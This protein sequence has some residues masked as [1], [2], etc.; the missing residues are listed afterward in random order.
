[1]TTASP[2]IPGAYTNLVACADD[3][4]YYVVTV[5]DG[6][7]I[8]VDIF[9]DD[10]EGDI[11]LWL[12]DSSGGT[13]ADSESVDDD[14]SI[15]PEAVPAAGTYYVKVLLYAD[16]GS[17]PGNTYDLALSVDLAVSTDDTFAQGPPLDVPATIPA[18]G[19]VNSFLLITGE[20]PLGGVVGD[21]T[22]IQNIAVTVNITHPSVGDL[23]LTL[24]T[25]SGPLVLSE[26]NGG[27]GA[28]FTD[29][30]FLDEYATSAT[31]PSTP[32]AAP[33]Y[34]DLYLAEDSLVVLR[35]VDING[36]W[37]LTVTNAGSS[38]G[39]IDSWLINGALESP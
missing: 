31:I 6:E 27:A 24:S 5:N 3:A 13:I 33:P 28:N 38:P 8:T 37:G 18:M 10:G 12:L 2:I 39:T 34:T 21:P 26:Q 22:E 15:G 30:V 32:G 25:P 11:D 35:G 14:E 20:A 17:S 16:D 23:T 36:P 7:A 4:D 29:T 19:S 1:L 9:F